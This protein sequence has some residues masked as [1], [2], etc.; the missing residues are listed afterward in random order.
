MGDPILIGVDLGGT[1]VRSGLVH[2][3]DLIKTSSTKIS[4]RGT[5]DE[6]ICEVIQCIESV[7]N[8][9]ARSIGIGVPGILDTKQGIVYDVQNIPCWK[10]VHLK[11]IIEQHF[12]VPV[13]L[14]NDANCFA[15]GEWHYGSG[16]G[17]KNI[18]GLILGTGV[19]SG[20]ILNNQLY[21]GRN[22]GAGEFGMIPYLEENIEFYCS[23][24]YFK[25]FYNL[26]GEEVYI[27]AK[28]GDPMALGIFKKYGKQLSIAVKAVLYTVDPDIIIL[29]G[30]VSKAFEFF[31]EPLLQSLQDF[32]Y[33]PV[34]KNILIEQ[35]KVDNIAILGA[36]ALYFDNHQ[37]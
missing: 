20:L 14:N 34:L 23:G 17:F 2:G 31:K 12:N 21:E 36:A 1:N 32:P 5:S 25:H 29:G 7:F 33:K 16:K 15:A 10:E 27:N 11:A 8:K 9:D 6:V 24:N 4:S 35:S 26:S 28:N 22:C 19:A 13:Y 37:N 3:E 30:S 18:A